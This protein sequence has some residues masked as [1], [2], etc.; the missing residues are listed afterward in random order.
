MLLLGLTW[1]A[2]ADRAQQGE[3]LGLF[4]SLPIMWSESADI[5]DELRGGQTPHWARAVLR[6]QGRIV[7]LDVLDAPGGKGPLGQVRRLVIAQ[8]RP[9]SGAENVALDAW[10]RGGGQLLLL[11]DPALTQESAFPVGDPRRP[12]AVVLISPILRHWG[13]DL[14]FD[15]A[16]AFGENYRAAQ[17]LSLPVNL[18]GRFALTGTEHCKLDGDGLLALC[19]IGKGRVVA[20]ADAALLESDGDTEAREKALSGL[21]NTA[22]AAD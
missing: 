4:T 7:P 17:G 21:L 20:L 13:L 8:P 5:A 11:A 15:D 9:L 1:I 12:Q 22:F 3:P 19:R 6:Q 16:Q 18:P 14:Q 10:V 2:R